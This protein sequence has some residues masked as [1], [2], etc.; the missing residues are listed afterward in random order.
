MRSS[1]VRSIATSPHRA[2]VIG[3]PIAQQVFA[4][5]DAVLGQDERVAELRGSWRL[6]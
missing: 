3:Q 5:A 6:V 1:L 2:K 4:I